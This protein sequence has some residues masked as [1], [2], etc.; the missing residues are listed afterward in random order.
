MT[1]VAVRNG[2]ELQRFVNIGSL[3]A[4]TEHQRRR[5]NILS[6]GALGKHANV[7]QC[8]AAEDIARSRAPG[9]SKSVL[10]WLTNVHKEIQALR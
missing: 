7:F 8:L 2:A 4:F 1:G 5:R 6:K 9:Y 3:P 10:D